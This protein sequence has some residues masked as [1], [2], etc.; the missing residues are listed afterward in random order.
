[1]TAA[2]K[3]AE[4]LG[5]PVV[6]SE[7]LFRSL[8]RLCGADLICD[9]GAFDGSHSKRF[10]LSGTR[11]AALEANPKNVAALRADPSVSAAGIEIFHRA[12]S[13]HD[14][15]TKFNVVDVPEGK[16]ATWA[17][18]IGSI[19][20]RAKDENRLEFRPVVVPAAR[21]D[22]FVQKELQPRPACIALWIDVEG[23]GYEALEGLKGISESVCVIHVEVELR[24]FWEGQRLWPHVARLMEQRGFVPVARRPG[25]FQ[26]DVVFVSNRVLQLFPLRVKWHVFKAW[27]RRRAGIVLRSPRRAVARWL[28]D[29]R[30][31]R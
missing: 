11:V 30:V 25:D 1:M 6:T 3:D 20:T 8:A 23:C 28:G 12:I 10:R 14:G 17:Q 22:S 16:G 15:E 31:G 13:N 2:T 18:S 4:A 26:V 19:R 5:L 27:S 21:L 9:V 24:R 7:Y 29:R